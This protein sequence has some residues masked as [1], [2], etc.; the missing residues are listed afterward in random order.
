MNLNVGA[1][2]ISL[3]IGP[4]KISITGIITIGPGNVSITGLILIGPGNVSITNKIT[5][6]IV[7]ASDAEL[8]LKPITVHYSPLQSITV[9]YSPL[10]LI[11]NP[12]VNPY[13]LAP[14]IQESHL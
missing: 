4:R 8:L 10:Q 12:P 7:I 11:L 5:A 2:K 1:I 3:T 14:P 9:H 13:L 6:S